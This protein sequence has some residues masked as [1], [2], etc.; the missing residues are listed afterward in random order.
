[1]AESEEILELVAQLV[2]AVEDVGRRSASRAPMITCAELAKLVRCSPRDRAQERPPAGVWPSHY[3]A[4]R[5]LFDEDQVAQIWE[6]DPNPAAAARR[7]A[8]P[9]V[10]SAQAAYPRG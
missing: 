9:R 7:A 1:M 6:L 3:V 4:E 10:P 5:Y 2:Q 8:Q